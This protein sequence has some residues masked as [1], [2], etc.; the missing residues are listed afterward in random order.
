LA[1]AG[2]FLAR[3]KGIGE[4]SAVKVWGYPVTPVLYLICSLGLMSVAF[5]G[6]PFASAVALGTIALGIP[7]YFLWVRGMKPGVK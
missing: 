1:I 7:C 6:R 2:I 4:A 5:A 3:K